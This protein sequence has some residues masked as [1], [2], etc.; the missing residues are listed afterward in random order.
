M[1][2]ADLVIRIEAQA[3]D[4]RLVT[5]KAQSPVGQELLQ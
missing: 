2:T 4:T 5:L 3:D 1:P